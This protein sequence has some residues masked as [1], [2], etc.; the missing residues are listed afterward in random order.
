MIVPTPIS[1]PEVVDQAH[2]Q[3]WKKSQ[4]QA[5]P[6]NDVPAEVLSFIDALSAKLPDFGRIRNFSTII[7]GYELLLAGMER[8]NGNPVSRWDNYQ[9][10]VPH[11]VVIDNR[12]T[13]L[14]LYKRKGKQGLIDYCRARVKG[15]E[16]QRLL[17]VLNVNVFNQQR[18]EFKRVLHSIAQQP[19]LS[20]I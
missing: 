14:R 13:M 6:T 10:D 11:M 8:W 19:K 2:L 4:E 9:M 7:T 15:T 18:P 17:D 5:V 12:T 3:S 1:L 16:L 20:E